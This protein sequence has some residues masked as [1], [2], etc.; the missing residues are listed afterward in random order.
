MRVATF[1]RDPLLAQRCVRHAMFGAE[2]DDVIDGRIRLC[3]MIRG[4]GARRVP[5]R[6]LWNSRH[7][8]RSRIRAT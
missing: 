3:R 4:R 8:I 2:L 1:D 7:D 6:S 5:R